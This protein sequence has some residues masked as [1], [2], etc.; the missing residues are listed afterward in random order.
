MPVSLD[1]INEKIEYLLGRVK[2]DPLSQASSELDGYL[3]GLR[4][5]DAITHQAA[6]DA[7]KKM[8]EIFKTHKYI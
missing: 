5:A 4:D 6:S 1:S 8:I 3:S 7:R 2:Q